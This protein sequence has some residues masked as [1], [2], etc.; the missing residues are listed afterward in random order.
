MRNKAEGFP[1][2]EGDQILREDY[3]MENYEQC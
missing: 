1:R 3:E 2:E